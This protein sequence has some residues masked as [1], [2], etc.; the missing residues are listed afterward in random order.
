MVASSLTTVTGTIP[1]FIKASMLSLTTTRFCAEAGRRPKAKRE[2][3]PSERR[4][5]FMDSKSDS[6]LT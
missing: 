2:R 1:C 5:N 4:M 3:S 6:S